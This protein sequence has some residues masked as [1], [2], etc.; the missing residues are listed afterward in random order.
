MKLGG[1]RGVVLLPIGGGGRGPD[2]GGAAR[3]FSG[4]MF[5]RGG[6]LDLALTADEL[7][8]RGGKNGRGPASTAETGSLGYGWRWIGRGPALVGRSYGPSSKER[9]SRDNERGVETAEVSEL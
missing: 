9:C 6:G 4:V 3:M 8:V 7:D 2:G 5:E 1:R